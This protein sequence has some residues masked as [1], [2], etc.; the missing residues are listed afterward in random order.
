M[1]P[2]YRL[3]VVRVSHE[4]RYIM[5]FGKTKDEERYKLPALQQ[6]PLQ[7]LRLVSSTMTL[8]DY[9]TLCLVN[10]NVRLRQPTDNG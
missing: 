8:R 7:G 9:L 2:I 5:V 3:R 1:R 4:R 10:V 6:R